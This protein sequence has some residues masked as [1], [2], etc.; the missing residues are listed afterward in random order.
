MFVLA[1]IGAVTV[2]VVTPPQYE[3]TAKLYVS[4]DVDETQRLGTGFFLATQ[5]KSYA[6]L[7]NHRLLMQQVIDELNLQLT[8]EQ[9]AEKVAATVEPETIILS[10]TVRDGDP[11][12]AQ[13]IAR[14]HSELF[15]EYL[16]DLE[17]P[18][19]SDESLI[20]PTITDPATYNGSPVLP[21]TPLNLLIAA[22]LGLLLGSALA[23]IRELLD[24]TIS[25]LD[26]ME[27]VI[28]APVMASVGVDP[29]MDKKPLLSD[30]KG[31]SPRGEAFR[32]LRTNLQFLDLDSDPKSLVITS[33]VA[34]EGKTTTSTNL[35]VALA[36]AGRRV[37]LV[38]GD[39]RRPRV[40]GLLGLESKIGLT[41]VLVGRTSSRTAS[42]ATSPADLLPGLWPD[43]A[44]PDRDPA[45]ARDPRPAAQAAR[46]VRRRH[47]RRSAAA[48]GGGR[49]DPRHRRRRR[50]HRGQAWQDQARPA[51]GCGRPARPGRRE[52]VRRRGQ[53]DPEALRQQ[54]LL[55]LLRRGRVGRQ[56]QEEPGRQAEQ[57]VVTSSA[58]Q[59]T[60]TV[61]SV[62]GCGYLGAVH[63]AAMAELGH[64][65]IGIDV[66]PSRAAT[67]SAGQ[68]PFSEPGYEELL[69]ANLDRGLLTFTD[70]PGRPRGDAPLPVRRDT[71]GRQAITTP[72]SPTSRGAVDAELLPISEARRR[73]HRQVRGAGRRAGAA[74]RRG[75]SAPL[76]PRPASVWNPEFLPGG[77]RG[78]G[79]PPTPGPDRDRVGDDERPT[80]P[81]RPSTA[82]SPATWRS[83]PQSSARY[84]TAE[85]AKVRPFQRVPRW[86][87]MTR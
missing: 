84:Q 42:S 25:S 72:T 41:T 17:T 80:P 85:L 33:A 1:I 11:R 47:H 15:V 64:T 16:K 12:L 66:A 19:A 13:E 14:V 43:A 24:T 35:A 76:R 21:N 30:L 2:S 38:D 20:K 78:R 44:E 34:G 71:A 62:I 26:Q 31:F 77:L 9:L 37:L 29:A 87:K 23:L 81:A 4:A 28:D 51:E 74:S 32:M 69:Q 79:H 53:H 52:A 83:T 49:R 55:L 58:Q 57:G 67:L 75:S 46:P 56:P 36:Q 48:A 61:I 63:A 40:A 68:A 50:D 6:V 10:V 22:A 70:D 45:V 18:P 39:L 59:P 3:S 5:V 65:V 86:T 7:A 8:P 82:A 54:L 60:G 73:R 27:E